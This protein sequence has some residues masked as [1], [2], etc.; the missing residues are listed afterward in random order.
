MP[1]PPARHWPRLLDCEAAQILPFS[2]GVILEPLPVERVKA[3]LPQAIANLKAD[4]WYPRGRSHHDHRHEPKAASRT[5]ANRRP[6]GDPDR[7][8]QG[9]R[10][11]PAEHGDHAGLRRHRCQGLP[12]RAGT[13]V[14]EA[15]DESFNCITID[16]DTSTNDS[17][18]LI[19]TGV[20]GG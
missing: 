20:G 19:A 2:T 12:A 4:N 7:H 16:G 13:L 8:Q 17:F 6:D 3:G 1:T 5:V 11:D 15:A 9:R 10:H 14:K 18:M